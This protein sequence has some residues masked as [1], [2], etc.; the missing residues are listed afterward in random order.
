MERELA[1]G[2]TDGS[3]FVAGAS[4]ARQRRKRWRRHT[5][6]D[7]D[8][9]LPRHAAESAAPVEVRFATAHFHPSSE[10]SL[11]DALTSFLPSAFHHVI[12]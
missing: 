9:L 8:V 1:K 2:P 7:G 4:M 11:P 6:H 10:Q 3:S 12:N 5:C